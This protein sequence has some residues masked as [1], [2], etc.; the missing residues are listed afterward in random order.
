MYICEMFGLCLNSP[1]WDWIGG[2]SGWY[3]EENNAMA[4]NEP[5]WRG[6]GGVGVRQTSAPVWR[7]NSCD[8]PDRQST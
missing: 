6:H 2:S 4:T 8:L 1:N 7:T 5:W 3:T